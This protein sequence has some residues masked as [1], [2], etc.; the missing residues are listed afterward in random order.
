MRAVILA[1]GLGTRLMPLTRDKPK[2]LVKVGRLSILDHMLSALGQVGI[3]EAVVVVGHLGEVVQGAIGAK[4]FG[5]SIKYVSNPLFDYHG[6]G[7][8][9]ALA[10]AEIGVGDTLVVEGDLILPVDDLVRIVD[11]EL[12]SAVLVDTREDIDAT[13]AVVVLGENGLVDGFVYDTSHVDVMEQVA[14]RSQV[15]GESMQTWRFSPKAS[16]ALAAE[17]YRFQQDVGQAPDSR[18]NLFPIN[19]VI[20][21]HPMRWIVR[22]DTPWFN[23]NSVDDI[24]AAESFDYVK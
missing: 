2:C 6:S 22:G 20:K 15:V 13:R 7:Y 9:I 14:D 19:E 23:I 4:R 21:T 16:E 5:V 17:L 10:A 18:T 3:G 8:S 24:R 12:E 11:P 1:A